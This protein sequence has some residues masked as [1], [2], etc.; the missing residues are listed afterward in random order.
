MAVALGDFLGGVDVVDAASFLKDAGV[1][2]K[3]H[4]AA[5][6][7]A[8]LALLQVASLHPFG[9]QPDHR[10]LAGAEFG[11][12]GAREPGHVAGRLD[13]CHLHAE[14]DAEIGNAPFP[15]E[16]GGSDLAFG[17]ALPW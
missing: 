1:G 9:H 7:A 16:A 3:P 4:G 2:A 14:T 5:Q 13:H 12:T 6:V 17:T 8:G 15:G 11:G 10:V